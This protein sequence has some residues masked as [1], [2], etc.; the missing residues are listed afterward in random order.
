M[1]QS[2]RGDGQYFQ[3]WVYFEVIVKRIYTWSGC[4][5]SEKWRIKE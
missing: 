2:P 5:L 1:A 4:W 3:G